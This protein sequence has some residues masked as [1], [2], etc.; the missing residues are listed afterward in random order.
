MTW[1]LVA[2]GLLC[3]GILLEALFALWVASRRRR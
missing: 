2:I 3:W 1:L